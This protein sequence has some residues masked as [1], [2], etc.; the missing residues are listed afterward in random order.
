MRSIPLYDETVPIVCTASSD[1][2]PVRIEVIQRIYDNLERVER[3]PHG[4]SLSFPSDPAIDADLRQFTVDEK[5]C[6]QFWGFAVEW[7]PD[8]LL[9]QWDG[10]PAVEELMNRLHD[11]FTGDDRDAVIGLF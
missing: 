7:A 8:A 9:L 5:G 10:P 6:C 2:I 4:L 3:T 1:E 11:Y